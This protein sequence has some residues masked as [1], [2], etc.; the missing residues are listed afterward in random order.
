MRSFKKKKLIYTLTVSA[1]LLSIAWLS[2]PSK[3]PVLS[4]VRKLPPQTTA[5]SNTA[6][7]FNKKLYS[8]DLSSSL[9]AVVNKGRI[10]PGSYYPPDLVR[11][12]IPLRYF[13]PN[14]EMTLRREA[15]AA[16]EKMS[17]A[18]SAEGIGLRLASGFRSYSQQAAVYAGYVRSSGSA[19]AD[20]FSARAGHSEHQ[21]GLAADLEPADRSC[22]LEVCF[23]DTPTGK[24]LASHSHKYG[25]IIRYQNNKQS[26]TGY[27][28]EPW[29][30][31]YVGIEL[32]NEINITGMTL[33]EFFGLP[34]YNYYPD[35]VVRLIE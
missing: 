21:T 6:L 32:A 2:L 28:F 34:T 4:P 27:Q 19:K 11:P 24:W 10:L 17:A 31:R 29:H 8:L 9:W 33:E 1:V 12:N 25:F 14:Q 3:K 15:A 18:A 5:Q 30:F 22:E 20:T 16:L 7:P 13:A 23:S 26:L 35:Q